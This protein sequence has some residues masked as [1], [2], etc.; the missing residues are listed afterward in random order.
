[1]AEWQ[2]LQ[3][4]LLPS[5]VLHLSLFYGS[6]KANISHS[7]VTVILQLYEQDIMAKC[8]WRPNCSISCVDKKDSVIF[9]NIKT[10]LTSATKNRATTFPNWIAGNCIQVFLIAI[11]SA[12]WFVAERMPIK[13]WIGSSGTGR[14]FHLSDISKTF[15]REKLGW[16]FGREVAYTEWTSMPPVTAKPVASSRVN[17]W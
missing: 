8:I 17:P 6:T 3:N 13:S 4:I 1:M 7:G 16:A 10:Y 12:K 15:C 2:R 14:A 9:K 5:L 11:R